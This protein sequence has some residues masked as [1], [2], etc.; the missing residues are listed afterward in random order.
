[1]GFPFLFGGLSVDL[2]QY[3]RKLREIENGI[4]DTYVLIASLETP[5]GGK[6]GMVTEVSRFNAAKMIIEGRAVLANEKQK[7]AYEAQ[8]EVLRKAAERAAMAKRVQVVLA[9]SEFETPAAKKT[10]DSPS[11]RK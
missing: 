9:D 7:E 4:A 5:D 11:T 3:F 10:S 1:M 8:Q 6:A 2:K